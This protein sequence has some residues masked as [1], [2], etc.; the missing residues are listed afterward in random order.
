[1]YLKL[2]F[3]I[4]LYEIKIFFKGGL[5]FFHTIFYICGKKKIHFIHQNGK[6]VLSLFIMF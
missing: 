1:M 6:K 2:H 5:D 4:L 3:V